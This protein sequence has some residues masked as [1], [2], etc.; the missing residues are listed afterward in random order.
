VKSALLSIAGWAGVLQAA[1]T[2]TP[3]TETW[4]RLVG[5]AGV[6]GTLTVLVYRLGVWRQ[7]MEHT[8]QNVVGE[9][10]AYRDDSAAAFE[11]IELR[12]TAI[13]HLFEEAIER[14]RRVERWQQRVE[15][16]IDW[17]ERNEV[18]NGDRAS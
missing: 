17:L 15:K 6:L 11:R 9:V 16:R 13:D 4:L 5:A 2:A 18:V 10:K 8:K 7:E 12:L 1:G 3:F 14:W